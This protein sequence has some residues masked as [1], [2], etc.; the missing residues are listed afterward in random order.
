MWETQGA[1]S[2]RTKEHLGASDE[3]IVMLR[4][5]MFENIEKVE[6]GED[7]L[8]IVRDDSVVID[9]NFER[10]LNLHYPR[11]TKTKTVPA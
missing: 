3:G 8:G 7:P 9:T 4:R 10:S 6:R 1:V 11:G 5:L 2:D